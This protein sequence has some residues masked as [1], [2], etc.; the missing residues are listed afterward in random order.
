VKEFK[1]AVAELAKGASLTL[2]HAPDG[3]DAFVAADLVR[4]LAAAGAEGAAALVHVA[5]DAQRSRMFQEGLA[6]TAPDLEV[7][8]FPAWDCQPYDRSSPNAGIVS[9]R[10]TVMARIARTRSSAQKPRILCTTIDAMLQRLPPRKFIESESFSAAPGN[11]IDMNG[12]AKWLEANG[13]LRSSTVRDTG[14]YAVR[15]GILDLF[16][17]GL[18]APLR[19]DFF[20]DTLE[21]I[22]TFDPE[23]QRT[24]A[25]LRA[26]DLVPMSEVQL[27]TETI[28]RFRQGYIAAFGAQTRGDGLYE[29]VSEG[30][31]HPGM[32]HWLPLY[33]GG[34]DTLFDYLGDAPLLL[35]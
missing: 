30:R 13:Y 32:E 15:G 19:L 12:L 11:A 33:Y 2:A 9:R 21:S 31:R 18:P 4:G 25:Q 29:A 34:A 14:E 10:M 1:R 17:P 27:T 35:D 6:F 20:G 28:R 26:L 24:T 8:D 7:L 3:F 16:P 5:R 23:T 22:R